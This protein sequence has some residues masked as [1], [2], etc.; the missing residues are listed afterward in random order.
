MQKADNTLK[1][2]VEQLFRQGMQVD[3]IAAELSCPSSEVQFIID[4]L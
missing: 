2:K 1:E 4:M 3:D